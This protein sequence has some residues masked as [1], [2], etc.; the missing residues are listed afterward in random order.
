MVV[1]VTKMNKT[2][3]NGFTLIELLVVIAIM[4]ILTVITVSQFQNARKK[5]RDVA[6]KGDLNAVSKSILMYYTDYGRLPEASEEGELVVDGEVIS[7]GGGE[8][9]DASG[10]IY[11]PTM[12]RENSAGMP[13]YCYLLSTDETKFAILSVLEND[14]DSEYNKYDDDGYT[15]CGHNNSYNFVYLSPNTS[16]AEFDGL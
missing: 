6:R 5:A 1:L 13:E 15:G 9:S 16:V 14:Q 7:W 12:P 3:K 11:M 10:Y 8:F 4:S 2:K